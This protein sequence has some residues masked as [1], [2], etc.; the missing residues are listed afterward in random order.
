ME[1]VSQKNEILPHDPR[2]SK[3]KRKLS[4]ATVEYKG[5]DNRKIW[6]WGGGGAAWSNIKKLMALILK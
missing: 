5:N 4:R 6:G 1:A 2:S 3:A